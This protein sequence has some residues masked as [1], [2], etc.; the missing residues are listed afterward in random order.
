MTARRSGPQT[1]SDSRTAPP[2]T[3][4]WPFTRRWPQVSVPERHVFT[5]PAI[6]FDWSPDGRR[7]VLQVF[8]AQGLTDSVFADVSSPRTLLDTY[9]AGPSMEGEPQFSPDGGWMAYSS[10]ESGARQVFVEPIPRTGKRLQLSAQLGREPRWS[11]DGKT[12]FFLGSDNTL[13]AAALQVRGVEVSAGPPMS[14]FKV[15]VTDRDVKYHYAVGRDGSRFLVNT[16][17]EDT[18]GTPI[19]VSVNWNNN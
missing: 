18:L 13:M 9:A 2:G 1:T 6:P 7:L 17:V 19:Q 12:V 4:A 3:V 15:R 5:G 16:I 11:G 8:N 14:L 10:S